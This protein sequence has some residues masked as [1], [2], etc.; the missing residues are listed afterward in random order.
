MSKT[1]VKYNIS[2]WTKISRAIVRF[3]MR[4]AYRL[5]VRVH[6]SGWENLP[7]NNAFIVAFNHVSYF[8]PPLLM[9]F[10]K[11]APEAIG[12]EYLFK[13]PVFKFLAMSYKAIPVN[14][15]QYDRKVLEICIDILDSGKTLLIAPEG[16][17]SRVKGMNQA[18]PGISYIVDKT[19][20]PVVPVA[21][22]GTTSDM[23][24][25]ALKL[26]RPIIEVKIG[27]PI[28]LPDVEGKGQERRNSRQSNADLVMI[29]IAELLPE[30]YHG[31]YANKTYESTL[32]K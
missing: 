24:K 22:I 16:T 32:S 15:G 9:S 14:R 31:Y 10:W 23:L 1:D 6:I 25:K 20:V 4:N 27:N 3:L 19:N 12:A 17:R 28:Y 11:P 30:E 29:K 26:K 18:N 13:H 8:E 21:C 7:E 2:F 5:L